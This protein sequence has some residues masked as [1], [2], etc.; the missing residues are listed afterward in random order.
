MKLLELI[1]VI[2]ILASLTSI[3]V[4]SFLNLARSVSGLGSYI[5][6]FKIFSKLQMVMMKA[7]QRGSTYTLKIFTREGKVYYVVRSVE[8]GV[9]DK[10][11][12][13]D[14]GYMTGEIMFEGREVKRSGSIYSREWSV[15]VQPV[16]GYIEV[17]RKR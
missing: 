3:T 11:K 17:Y 13:L 4:G 1:L 16:T 9:V 12:L 14:S 5:T 2:A 8:E 7:K 6:K 15:S 10:G